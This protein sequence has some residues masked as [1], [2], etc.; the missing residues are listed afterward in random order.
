MARTN[1]PVPE[2]RGI[3][4][5]KDD[6]RRAIRQNVID[7]AHTASI[8]DASRHS[9]V[10]VIPIKDTKQYPDG[11]SVMNMQAPQYTEDQFIMIELLG[12]RYDNVDIELVYDFLKHIDVPRVWPNIFVHQWAQW[13]RT[14]RHTGV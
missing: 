7:S 10:P 13:R 5:M 8:Y 12:H 4:Q 1:Y 2:Q 6:V 14:W 11:T 3:E 9:L